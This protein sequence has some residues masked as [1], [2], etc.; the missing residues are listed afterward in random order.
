[1]GKK[2]SNKAIAP[3]N[4]SEEMT[5][6]IR[7]EK[8]Y[9]ELL[10][11]SVSLAAKLQACGA[12]TYRVEETISRV[13]EAYGVKKNDSFVIPGCIMASLETDDG[14]IISKIRRIK[15]GD[16]V[17]DGIERYSALCRRIC[18]E[19]PP[20]GE[21]RRMLK[22]TEHSV[23]HYGSLVY[24]FSAFLIG[25][26]F[27]IFFG[28]KLLEAA[29]AGRVRRRHGAVPALYGQAQRKHFLQVLRLQLHTGVHCQRARRGAVR[30][31]TR[32]SPPSA[33]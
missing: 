30:Q 4:T 6:F 12:E 20:I 29:A 25:I 31:K 9:E 21:A 22:E 33:R 14:R 32:I 11:F 8:F 5:E 1:M 26:G 24:Y 10:E 18:A 13:I 3:S 16:T 15:G 23:R 28:G 19:K 27:G 17:L 7:E 2:R